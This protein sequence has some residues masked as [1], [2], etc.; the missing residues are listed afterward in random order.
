MMKFE[1]LA[2]HLV[3]LRLARPEQV[4]V[5]MS[6]GAVTPS[7]SRAGADL[8][9][10][11]HA[12]QVEI[13]LPGFDGELMH[14]LAVVTAWLGDNGGDRDSFDGWSEEPEND[15]QSMVTLRLTL[16]DELRY[17]LAEPGYT[18][19]DKIT[20]GGVDW[21]PGNAGPDTATLASFGGVVPV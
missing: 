12:G 21:K 9:L 7:Y 3:G 10:F 2:R 15:Q 13:G 6:E 8:L 1:I 5:A 14:L 19:R 17:V 11:H 16:E 4:R 20:L 18:G